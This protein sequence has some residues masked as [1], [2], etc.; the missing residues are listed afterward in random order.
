MS[1]Y[2]DGFIFPNIYINKVRG[3]MVMN[4]KMK[5]TMKRLT[6]MDQYIN[7]DVRNT[8]ID[9]IVSKLKRG[10]YP[11]GPLE[12]VENL[13]NRHNKIMDKKKKILNGG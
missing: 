1:I 8:Y 5:R 11:K 4:E 13:I 6:E 2:F 10:I 3:I 12:R 9:H 7:K